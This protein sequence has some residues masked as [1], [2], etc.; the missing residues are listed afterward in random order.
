MVSD[1]PEAEVSV[2]D[3]VVAVGEHAVPFMESNATLTAL[4]GLLDA[5][6]GF[7]H[8]I[9]YRRPVAWLLVGDADRAAGLID[10]TES[11]LGSRDDAA[12]A[13][14]R[15]FIAAFRRRFLVNSAG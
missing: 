7:E 6:L 10:A 4:C 5:G 2:A 12:A 14:L 9:V 1:A 13:E 11:S 3:L 15:A 8:Q